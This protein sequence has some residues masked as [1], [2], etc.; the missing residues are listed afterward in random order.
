LTDAD[1]QALS[2]GELSQLALEKAER[3]RVA[4]CISV[5]WLTPVVVF[6][7]LMGIDEQPLR[8]SWSIEPGLFT[9][10]FVI[11]FVVF[12]VFLVDRQLKAAS[13]SIRLLPGHQTIAPGEI[14]LFVKAGRI[15]MILLVIYLFLSLFIASVESSLVGNQPIQAPDIRVILPVVMLLF[16]FTMVPCSLYGITLFGRVLGPRLGGKLLLP[17]K[18]RLLLEG[19]VVVVICIASFLSYSWLSG[20]D[21]SLSVTV[22][23]GSLVCYAIL[24]GWLASSGYRNSISPLD[25]YLQN[26]ESSDR[27]RLLQPKS[28]DE[29]A[30]VVWQ[31]CELLT[32]LAET[33]DKVRENRARFQHF[34]E[35]ASDFYFEMDE[36]CNFSFLSERFEQLTEIPVSK[37]IGQSFDSLGIGRFSPGYADLMAD[38]ERHQAIRNFTF[39]VQTSN[40]KELHIQIGA[41][42][43]MDD[44]NSFQGYRGS[45]TDISDLFEAREI[46]AEQTNALAQVQKMEAVGQLTGGVAHDF[47]NLL[48]VILGNLEMI[49]FEEI[50]PEI[51]DCVASATAA[52]ES[53]AILVQR[54]LA[55]SR[56]QPLSP[57]N[58]KP[59]VLLEKM[60]ELLSRTL[61]EHVN[62]T[63]ETS[64]ES[65]E[66]F[67]DPAQFES[68]VLNLAI[69]ARDAM[70]SGGNLTFKVHETNIQKTGNLDPGRYVLVD[71][72][73]DGAGM[74]ADVATA[75]FDPFFTTK[76][77]GKGSG[78][79]LSMVYG[80]MR[81]SKGHVSIQ[82]E[83]AKGTCVTLWIPAAVA[84]GAADADF[85]VS[86]AQAH[87]SGQ[88]LLVVEDDDSIRKLLAMQLEGLDYRVTTAEDADSALALINAGNPFDLIISDIVLAN[89]MNGIDMGKE[90]QRVRPEI[91]ILFLSGYSDRAEEVNAAR[92]LGKPFRLNQLASKIEGILKEQKRQDYE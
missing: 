79:G 77:V 28:V 38:I 92:F 17:N 69:N 49:N 47:N 9:Y 18:V 27:A 15:G 10:G 30:V 54:L 39:S 40:G 53:G 89:G 29:M 36:N 80:F 5:T 16:V 12:A 60:Q 63:V 3:M 75:A 34:A 4:A 6:F 46:L 87:G 74:D 70:A 66:C 72:I 41:L 11:G 58:V 22:L 62:I 90:I 23:A 84:P 35:S 26:P 82:S 1:E 61:G 48:T 2:Q 7:V 83:K 37:I 55:F 14:R 24:I 42:P 71:I 64:S 43:L 78:L 52:A 45:G 88:N 56:K 19:P 68:A 76:E 8:G 86:R 44:A 73:D 85:P 65:I 25:R 50:A 32:R 13:A 57:A 67:V 20:Y 21:I 91:E 51:E 59:V 31:F 81:Q 33:H